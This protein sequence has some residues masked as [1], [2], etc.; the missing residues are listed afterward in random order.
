MLVL[1]AKGILL[2]G[3]QD[4]KIEVTINKKAKT[5]FITG[6]VDLDS[7]KRIRMYLSYH[8]NKKGPA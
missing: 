4:M 7:F 3:L 8:S 5:N 1:G 2:T 6:M